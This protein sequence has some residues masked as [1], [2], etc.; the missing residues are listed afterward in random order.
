MLFSTINELQ[1]K[2]QGGAGA[3]PADDVRVKLEEIMGQLPDLHN[4]VDI[5]ERLDEDRSPQAHVFYQECERTNI[6]RTTLYSTLAELDLGLKGALSMS[7]AMQELF[8]SMVMDKIPD[9]WVKVSFMSLRP[10]GSWFFN[11]LERNSQLAEWTGELAT[12]KVCNH[13]TS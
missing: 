10:M 7:S 5:S 3:D 12:P 6:L 9:N 1:P 2:Q 13:P 11:F 8:D 4:L